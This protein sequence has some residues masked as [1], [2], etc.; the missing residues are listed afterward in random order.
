M[1]KVYIDYLFEDKD[2]GEMFFVE[3]LKD[4]S[5]S[6]A[7]CYYEARHIASKN[8]ENPVFVQTMSAALAETYGYDTY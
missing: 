3:I 5:K 8:F 2:T 7:D 4:T 1:N 6:W